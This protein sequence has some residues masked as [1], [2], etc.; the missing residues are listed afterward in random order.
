MH[1]NTDFRLAHYRR[2]EVESEAQEGSLAARF[3]LTEAFFVELTTLRERNRAHRELQH[4]ERACN[5]HPKLF[6]PSLTEM[7]IILP[8]EWSIF[9]P[10]EPIHA[11]RF[12]QDYLAVVRICEQICQAL[13]ATRNA[14]MSDIAEDLAADASDSQ[15]SA[16]IGD[17]PL[18]AGCDITKFLIQ[19]SRCIVA[20][21]AKV[22]A[23]RQEAEQDLGAAECC[24]AISAQYLIYRLSVAREAVSIL[25]HYLFRIETRHRVH[26]A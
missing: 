20:V 5:V 4:V 12:S 15:P 24:V 11:S 23:H 7:N 17:T 6:I 26:S 16:Q 2:L 22:S 8:A 14:R 21:E 10:R 1:L 13:R 19:L 3:R 18:P 25:L 9:Q